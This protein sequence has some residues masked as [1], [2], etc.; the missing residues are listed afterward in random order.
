[1]TT[2]SFRPHRQGLL[3]PRHRGQLQWRNARRAALVLASLALSACAPPRS[4]VREVP[5]GAQPTFS[6][7]ATAQLVA[8]IDEL[9]AQ[10]V[11]HLLAAGANPNGREPDTSM[12][13]PGK[14]LL[15]AAI[16]Q[17]NDATIRLLLVA[18]ADPN[19]DAFDAMVGQHVTLLG[20][21]A[22][23][24]Q[25]ESANLLL[26]HGA[27]IDAQ[28]ED[29]LTAAHRAQ[30]GHLEM[31]KM[32]VRRGASLGLVDAEGKTILLRA[33]GQDPEMLAF[34]LGQH[35]VDTNWRDKLGRNVLM[36]AILA[37][38]VPGAT[39]LLGRVD[40]NARTRKGETALHF[41]ASLGH[42]ALVEALVQAGADAGAVDDSGSSVLAWAAAAGATDVCQYFIERGVDIHAESEHGY[43]A[44]MSAS[45]VGCV[46]A[47]LQ[48]G[49]RV[50]AISS[51]RESALTFAVIDHDRARVELLLEAGADPTLIGGPMPGPFHYAALNGDEEIIRAIAKK[52]RKIDLRDDNCRTPLMIAA[53]FNSS[54][55]V[56]SLLELGADPLLRDADGKTARQL[57]SSDN[58]VLLSVLAE[59]E[60]VSSR[61]RGRS[62]QPDCRRRVPTMSTAPNG[63]GL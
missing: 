60:A 33:A 6:D 43:T 39:A 3:S 44:L 5:R 36:Q 24:G 10:L 27:R 21:S 12:G 58:S 50:N 55:G 14:L 48:R 38:N 4:H 9:D 25:L 32:L 2:S 51:R 22:S 30:Y 11:S 13:Q 37:N 34:L 16:L 28:G 35:D 59:A 17:R 41:A 18:G 40:I 47:L 46:R 57:V 53:Q 54:A 62:R 23:L 42:M 56:N 29:G 8:S 7:T 61:R 15:Q 26:S 52:A 49:A 19:G 31:L 20:M 45:S 63:R 1:M